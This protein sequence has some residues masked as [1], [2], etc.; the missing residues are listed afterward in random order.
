MDAILVKARSIVPR[1][2]LTVTPGRDSLTLPPTQA[3]ALSESVDE[4]CPSSGVNCAARSAGVRLS[5][6]PCGRAVLY[7]SRQASMTRR[8]AVSASKWCAFRHSSRSRSLKLSMTQFSA[9]RPVQAHAACTRPLVQWQAHEL[10]P[11]VAD[12][13]RGRRA[14]QEHGLQPFNDAARGERAIDEDEWTLARTVV[15]ERPDAER[16][17]VGRD[18]PDEVHT[19]P[20]DRPGRRR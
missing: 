7:S 20:L 6:P 3:T 14:D 16:S 11:V 19:P 15:D 10:R 1:W 12:D 13:G 18:C 17:P 4:E 8:A 2:D 5:M 9:G